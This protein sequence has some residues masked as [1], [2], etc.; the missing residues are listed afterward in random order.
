MKPIFSFGKGSRQILGVDVGA[1]TIKAVLLSSVRGEPFIEGAALSPTPQDLLNKE[2]LVKNPL[3]LAE[4]LRIVISAYNLKASNAVV[5]IASDLVRTTEFTI[6]YINID[7]VGEMVKW[8]GAKMLDFPIEES[9]YDYKIL[10]VIE[11]EG[12]KYY[13]GLLVAVP[14][15]VLVPLIKGFSRARLKL[16]AIEVDSYAEVR[17]LGY[18]PEFRENEIYA[19]LNI[20]SSNSSLS[21][22]AR[23]R[24]FFSRAIPFCGD[25]VTAI[26]KQRLQLNQLE[27]E[28][29]KKDEGL[30]F[31]AERSHNYKELK[32]RITEILEDK[33]YSEIRRSQIFAQ[34]EWSLPIGDKLNLVLSGGGA[35]LKGLVEALNENLEVNTIPNTSL[36]NIKNKKGLDKRFLEDSALLLNCALGLALRLV[37]EEPSY[38]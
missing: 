32:L 10:E 26:I 31:D 9:G 29:F 35:F 14:N 37:S 11:K 38:V 4:A 17:T 15:T 2:G 6:P 13:K 7:D 5:A 24:I 23:G 1:N 21:F 36:L 33:L 19:I 25:M 34:Q 27:A 20:G 28:R 8:E 30:L 22:Y 3:A 16:S 18:L 12:K